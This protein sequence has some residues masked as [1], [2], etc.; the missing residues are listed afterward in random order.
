[1]RRQSD[2]GVDDDD[3]GGWKWMEVDGCGDV[4]SG[5]WGVVVVGGE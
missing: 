4:E 5:E 1:L 3:D 2:Q